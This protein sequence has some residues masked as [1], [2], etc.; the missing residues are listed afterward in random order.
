MASEPPNQ[1]SVIV[2]YNKMIIAL[3][4]ALLGVSVT[5]AEKLLVTPRSFDRIALISSWVLLVLTI[6]AAVMSAAFCINYLRN[7]ERDKLSILFAN[8]SFYLLLLASIG[9]LTLGVSRTGNVAEVTVASAIVIA[10]EGVE[11]ADPAASKWPIKSVAAVDRNFVLI[12]DDPN[13]LE[14]YS[15][16]V[17]SISRKIVSVRRQ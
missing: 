17:D 8:S 11:Q 13:S 12:F 16:A 7:D 15:I 4:S 3:A 2:E 6:L 10:R 1:W 5:F 14:S 9:F